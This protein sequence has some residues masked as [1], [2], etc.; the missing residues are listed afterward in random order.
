[1][2]KAVFT[3]KVDPTYD[4]LPEARY[5]FPQTYLRQAESAVGDWIVYYEPRRASGDAS[6]RGGRQAYFATAKV[7]RIEPDPAHAGHFYAFMSNYLEFDRPV[8]FKEGERY[9]EGA[10]ARADGKTNKGA[11]GRA[12]RPV[13]DSDYD[14]ILQAGFARTIGELANETLEITDDSS[15]FAEEQSSYKRPIMERVVSRPFR[16]AAFAIAVKEAYANTCAMTGLKIING[17]GRAEVQAAHIRPVAHRGSDSIRNGLALSGTIHWMFDRGLVSIDEDYTIVSGVDH[18]LP[19]TVA[20]MLRTTLLQ[21]NRADQRPHA[22]S[23]LPPRSN[24]QGLI[25]SAAKHPAG[26]KLLLTF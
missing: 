21:P 10:L 13:P 8:P 1:M 25:N 5:H 3:T 24:L 22:F 2:T 14:L 26:G 12:V 23:S 20:R 16:D 4:D 15:D 11:F 19:D 17:G 9:F 6:S 18:R 7:D